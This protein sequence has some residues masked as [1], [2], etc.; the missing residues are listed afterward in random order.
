MS[1]EHDKEFRQTTIDEVRVESDW[2]WSIKDADGWCFSIQ[3]NTNGVVP[4]VGD[5]VRFYGRGVGSVVRGVTINGA[6]VYYRTSEEQEQHN[7]EQA[8]AR[9]QAERERFEKDRASLDA[10]YDALPQVFRERIDKF[11]NNNPDFRWKFESYE[12][13]CCE[14][15]VLFAAA[16]KTGDAIRSFR[17]LPWDD[18]KRAVPGLSDDHSG[19]TFGCACSLAA[20]YVERPEGVVKSYGALAPLVGS[21]EYGCVK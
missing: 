3:K 4:K 2:G 5:T 13:F 6:V 11:R 15:A 19:N 9:E 7:R 8:A 10:R 1:I 18:Q 12:M 14:Q 17:Q 21:K 20:Y 16:L